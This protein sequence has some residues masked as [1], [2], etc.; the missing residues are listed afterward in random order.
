MQK[1]ED[2]I[3]IFSAWSKWKI[4][5]DGTVAYISFGPATVRWLCAQSVFNEIFDVWERWI[6]ITGGAG[7]AFPC[8]QSSGILTTGYPELRKIRI[9]DGCYTIKYSLQNVILM[10]P[11]QPSTVTSYSLSGVGLNMCLVF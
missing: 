1:C 3:S 10:Q 11:T 5:S 9:S 4:S 2:T 6:S 7:T 8:V